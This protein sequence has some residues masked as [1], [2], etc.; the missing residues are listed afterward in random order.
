MSMMALPD[1]SQARMLLR[2]GTDRQSGP[3]CQHVHRP[4][5]RQ[6]NPV[7]ETMREGTEWWATA[8]DDGRCSPMLN[9]VCTAKPIIGGSM[10]KESHSKAAD[11]HETAAKSHRAAAEQHG[12]GDHKAAHE[13]STKAHEHSTNAHKSSTEAHGKSSGKK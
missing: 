5:K 12:K 8:I 11:H 1:L 4:A 10:P 6:A 7:P 3:D 2:S 13:H 9:G